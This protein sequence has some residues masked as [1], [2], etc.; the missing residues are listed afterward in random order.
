MLW[1][2]VSLGNLNDIKQFMRFVIG[3]EKHTTHL[4]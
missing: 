3:F 2:E 1:L 4:H